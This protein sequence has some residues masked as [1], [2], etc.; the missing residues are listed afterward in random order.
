M[1]LG[2]VNLSLSPFM[3]RYFNMC[4]L[5]PATFSFDLC[6]FTF[7]CVMLLV[8][9]WHTWPHLN[10]TVI[11]HVWRHIQ[12]AW[13][14]VWWVSFASMIVFHANINVFVSALDVLYTT[15]LTAYNQRLQKKNTLSKWQ[16]ECCSNHVSRWSI[17]LLSQTIYSGDCCPSPKPL[18][19]PLEYGSLC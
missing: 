16:L 8:C 1:F 5:C 17:W 6:D 18:S 12:Y 11:R 2:D 7:Q 9:L 10:F 14:S 4:D 15:T 19:S 13:Q 3:W